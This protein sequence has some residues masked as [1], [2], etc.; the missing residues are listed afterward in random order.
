MGGS[1]ATTTTNI[2]QVPN[3]NFGGSK[4]VIEKNNIIGKVQVGSGSTATFT[5]MNLQGSY[6]DMLKHEQDII[7]HRDYPSEMGQTQT[8]AYLLI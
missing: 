6:W 8:K 3:A 7:M 2:S 4:N 5:L 1:K